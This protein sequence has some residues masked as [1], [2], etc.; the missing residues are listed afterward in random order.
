MHQVTPAGFDQ[1]TF[2]YW[3]MTTKLCAPLIMLDTSWTAVI[4]FEIFHFGG[5]KGKNHI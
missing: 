1:V 2:S 5:F 4:L 3:P